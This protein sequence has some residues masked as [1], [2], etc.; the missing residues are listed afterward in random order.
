MDFN[1]KADIDI[2]HM[3]R[4]R[5]ANMGRSLGPATNES[6]SGIIQESIKSMY[7]LRDILGSIGN[8]LGGPIPETAGTDKCPSDSISAKASELRSLIRLAVNSAHR[9]GSLL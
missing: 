3:E 8:A 2:D 9:I 4:L 6:V 7:E 5:T 1:Q